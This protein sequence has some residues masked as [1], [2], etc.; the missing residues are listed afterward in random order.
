M[1][2]CCSLDSLILSTAPQVF[3]VALGEPAVSS[4]R[5]RLAALDLVAVLA[6]GD[7]L[8]FASAISKDNLRPLQLWAQTLLTPWMWGWVGCC[9]VSDHMQQTPSRPRST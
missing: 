9:M 3:A 6:L 8:S 7:C 4:D 5:L 2:G 1:S